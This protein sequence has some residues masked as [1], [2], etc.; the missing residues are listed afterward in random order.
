M[1]KL[2]AVI[3]L[4]GT[5]AMPLNAMAYCDENMNRTANEI[6]QC[7]V[8]KGEKNQQV[9]LAAMCDVLV[10]TLES[11]NS[12]CNAFGGEYTASRIALSESE[13][14]LIALLNDSDAI[15][16]LTAWI[17]RIGSECSGL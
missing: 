12:N 14:L 13:S 1:K 4:M 16:L 5:L 8:D 7:I 6:D 15:G 10:V 17:W 2:A 3:I 11:P 9:C